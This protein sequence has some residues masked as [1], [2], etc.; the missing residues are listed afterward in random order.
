[1]TPANRLMLVMPWGRVG[2]NLLMNMLGQR[3]RKT[4]P[5]DRIA[6]A[7]ETINGIEG[8]EDQLAWCRE[9]YRLGETVAP[10]AFICSKQN[11]RAMASAQSLLSSLAAGGVCLLRLRRTDF[12]KA[13]VSQIRAEIYA[14]HTREKD[15][16]ARWAVRTGESGLDAVPIEPDLLLERVRI[17]DEADRKLREATEGCA[18]YDVE[19][20][21]IRR[22]PEAVLDAVTD[23]L[24]LAKAPVNIPFAKATPD[25]LALAISN[26]ADVKSALAGT[27]YA[28][29]L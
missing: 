9:F 12:V 8:H 3:V 16:V 7:N 20:E 5:K 29:Q 13:A 18:V 28:H 22:D 19:Y 11:V 26:Y 6:F 23:H 27:G 4:R 21:E 10:D 17:M 14:Q 15:G 24:G 2:S 25:D 1:M